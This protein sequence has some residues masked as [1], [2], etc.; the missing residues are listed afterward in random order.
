MAPRIVLLV[1]SEAIDSDRRLTNGNGR[2]RSSTAFMAK[3]T[4]GVS[5]IDDLLDDRRP[6]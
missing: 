2:L 3:L 1:T 4:W 5:L 6:C